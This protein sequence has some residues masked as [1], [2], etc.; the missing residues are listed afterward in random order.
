MDIFYGSFMIEKK[1][2]SVIMKQNQLL[3]FALD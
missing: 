2:K 3:F 1:I